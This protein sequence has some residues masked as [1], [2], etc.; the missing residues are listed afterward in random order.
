M[1]E[2]MNNEVMETGVE[3]AEATSGKGGKGLLVGLGVAAAAAIGAGVYAFFKKRKA[4]TDVVDEDY[5]DEYYDEEI[6]EDFEE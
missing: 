3:V 1:E 2:I 5:E 4:N 6:A